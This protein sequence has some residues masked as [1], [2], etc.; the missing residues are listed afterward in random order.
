MTRLYLDTEFNGFEG[1][2]ISLALYRPGGAHF[3]E[4]VGLP[5][6]PHPFV[7]EHVLPILNH[8]PVGYE[9]L[10]AGLHAYL[11]DIERPHIIADWQEDFIH[12]NR[13]LCAERGQQLQLNYTME[14]VITPDLSPHWPNRHNA[15]ADARG[16]AK[17]HMRAFHL[18]D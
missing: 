13:L 17:W 16:L 12:F 18:P 4:V 15:L 2:L 5:E 11:L 10:K 6:N 14:L 7:A 1:E 3:Y 9:L 8:G